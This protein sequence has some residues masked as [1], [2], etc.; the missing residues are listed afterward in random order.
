MSCLALKSVTSMQRCFRISGPLGHGVTHD[1][2]CC[3]MKEFPNLSFSSVL[4]F[5]KIQTVFISSAS[6]GSSMESKF[7]ILPQAIDVVD[8]IY[9]FFL[10]ERQHKPSAFIL[11]HLLC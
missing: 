7:N 3:Y 5:H 6:A 8:F 11:F 10:V 9:F 1:V 4:S 2:S